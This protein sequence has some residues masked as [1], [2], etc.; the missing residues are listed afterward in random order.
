MEIEIVL[1]SKEVVRIIGEYFGVK[2]EDVQVPSS[3]DGPIKVRVTGVD[4][5][6]LMEFSDRRES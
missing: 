5:G 1:D 4:T 6:E 3:E 2:D